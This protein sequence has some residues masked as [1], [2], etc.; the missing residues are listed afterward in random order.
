[1]VGIFWCF[2]S[3][4]FWAVFHSVRLAAAMPLPALAPTM[5]APPKINDQG[6]VP[7]N[8]SSLFLSCFPAQD[9]GTALPGANPQGSHIPEG[10]TPQF[11]GGTPQ[12][13]GNTPDLRGLC[14]L[15]Q[16]MPSQ[17]P[18]E[19]WGARCDGFCLL[20]NV[21]SREGSSSLGLFSIGFGAGDRKSVV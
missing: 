16:L 20:L 12:F 2:P 11:F 13:W 14:L 18:L 5:A 6:W 1:M 4:L 15:A 9:K 3:I 7:P 17:A 8:P 21:G 19:P 10:G